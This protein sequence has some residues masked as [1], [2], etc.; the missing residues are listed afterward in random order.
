MN[1]YKFKLVAVLIALGFWV[2][3]SLLHVLFFNDSHMEI[4]PNDANEIWMRILIILLLLAF[5]SFVDIH[6]RLLTKKEEEKT[7]VYEAMIY[8]SH[9]ILNIFLHQMQIV[10]LAAKDCEDFDKRTLVV[11]DEIVDE[12]VMLIDKLGQVPSLTREDI[13]AAVRL[14]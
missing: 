2:L 9:N 8:S 14:R 5:G 12:A 6:M 1:N 10:K 4:I 11:F 7:D 13:Q 3:E